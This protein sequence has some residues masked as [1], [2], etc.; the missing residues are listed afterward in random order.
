MKAVT[1]HEARIGRESQI[2]KSRD[3]VCRN[4]SL[5]VAIE[6]CR[7]STKAPAQRLRKCR[8]SMQGRQPGNYDV[9]DAELLLQDSS[10]FSLLATP[11]ITPDQRRNVVDSQRRYG[12]VVASCRLFF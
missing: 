2:E 4:V 11:V 1:C 3:F 5:K 10:Q 7:A 12:Y 6:L 8:E 9:P